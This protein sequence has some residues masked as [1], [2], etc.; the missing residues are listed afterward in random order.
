MQ[1]KIQ[2]FVVVWEVIALVFARN[3]TKNPEQNTVALVPGKSLHPLMGDKEVREMPVAMVEDN[4]CVVKDKCLWLDSSC[5]ED[6][7]RFVVFSL[8]CSQMKP[9]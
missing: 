8:L 3:N 5:S 6:P 9:H 7:Q 1:G 2:F 4:F